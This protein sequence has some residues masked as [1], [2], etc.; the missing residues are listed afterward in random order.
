ME[1]APD[2]YFA[3]KEVNNSEGGYTTVADR[4]S[5]QKAPVAA[6]QVGL[7]LSSAREKQGLS[8]D[9]MSVKTR[10]RDVHL[11][12]LEAGAIEKLPGNAFVTGFMRLYAKNLGI[13]DD[14][15]IERFLQEFE[16]QRQNLVTDT[17]S[18]PEGSKKR[19]NNGAI[20]GGIV[21]L[22]ALSIAYS[23]FNN[24]DRDIQQ[25]PAAPPAKVGEAVPQFVKKSRDDEKKDGSILH[26]GRQEIKSPQVT[27][28]KK[29]TPVAKEEAKPVKR[30]EIAK[31]QE[32]VIQPPK[33]V[34]KP[35]RAVRTPPKAVIKPAKVVKKPAKVVK[36]P[37]KVDKKP[38]KL[39]KPRIK[40]ASLQKKP[41]ESVVLRP[42]TVVAPSQTKKQPKKVVPVKRKPTVVRA[43]IEKSKPKVKV[44]VEKYT[45]IEDIKPFKAKAVKPKKK[46]VKTR[47]DDSKLSPTKRILSRYPEAIVAKQDLRPDS[48]QAVS[49]ISKE[50]VWVQIR[51]EDG[52]VLKDMV[53][54]PNHVFRVPTGMKFFAIIGNAG[55]VQLRVGSK[56]L[57]YLGDPGE[58]L[59]DLDLSAGNLLKLAKKR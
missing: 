15:L 50:L 46:I 25:L 4:A 29:E 48:R 57:P 14:P 17:F 56:K 23:N 39:V 11:I 52:D 30:R 51:N 8:I 1:Q 32:R 35:I 31:K 27:P 47:V 59:Q 41:G 3:P 37:V 58:V 12:S 54:R 19:P 38:A 45:P 42:K 34:K 22:V 40:V 5:A 10:I 49:L 21:G 20:I 16:K 24:S 33:T 7:L 55:G 36:K 28:P 13:V 43:K 26:F 18:P 53:M 9:E 6:T 2:D 44:R